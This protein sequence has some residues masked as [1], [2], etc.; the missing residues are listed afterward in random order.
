MFLL[1]LKIQI[2]SHHISNII[3][4]NNTKFKKKNNWLLVHLII[5]TMGAQASPLTFGNMDLLLNQL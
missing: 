4:C 3:G 1:R 2:W 5:L